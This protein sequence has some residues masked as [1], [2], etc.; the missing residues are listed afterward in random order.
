LVIDAQEV[1]LFNRSV[2]DAKVQVDPMHGGETRWLLVWALIFAGIVAAFQIGKAPIAIPLIRQ[3]LNLSLTF[4]AWIIGV[5]A[6]VGALAG[7]PAGAVINALGARPC[8][9]FGLLI[10]GAA[11]CSGAFA[12]GGVALLTTR[13]LEGAGFLMVAVAT[14]TLLSLVTAA[15]D[16]DLVF[17]AFGWRSAG[18]SI[19]LRAR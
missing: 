6:T 4:A 18:R 3:E 11:S 16:R 10:I 9:I 17:A 13:V 12:T 5:Y 19:S 1:L 7:L 8:V 2:T 15:K 14:P